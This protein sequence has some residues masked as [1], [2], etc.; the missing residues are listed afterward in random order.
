M[1]S[2]IVTGHMDRH[3]CSETRIHQH[4]GI[5]NEKNTVVEICCLGSTRWCIRI[6]GPHVTY[7]MNTLEVSAAFVPE[8]GQPATP[9]DKAK[10]VTG[11][12]KRHRS[13][14]RREKGPDGHKAAWRPRKRYRVSAEK[15]ILAVD[16]AIKHSTSL[17]GLAFSKF[18]SLSNV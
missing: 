13:W 6:W 7:M 17:P 15:W 12:R 10:A 11:Q 9:A 3:M 8:E 5:E 2:Q 1:C 16:N 18:N 14:L 4:F